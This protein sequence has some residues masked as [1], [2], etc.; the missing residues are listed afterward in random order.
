MHSLSAQEEI[1]LRGNLQII[2]SG[3]PNPSI[4]N[5]TDFEFANIGGGSKTYTFVIENIGNAPLMIN[6]IN[7]TGD[8]S[9]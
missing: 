8:F 1:Q 2:N 6:S 7:L 5:R 9:F 3:S 4:L